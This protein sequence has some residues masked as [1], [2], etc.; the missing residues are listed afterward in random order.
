MDD[1]IADLKE[2][3]FDVYGPEHLTTYVYFTDGIRIGYAQNDR[4]EGIKYA[5]VHKAN[6]YTG[7]GFQAQTWMEALMTIPPG[8]SGMPTPTKYASFEAF[9]KQY[10][11]QLVQL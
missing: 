6:Q 8:F 10:W 1:L 11:Q 7:T 9:R 5:T 4:L 2:M 3:D